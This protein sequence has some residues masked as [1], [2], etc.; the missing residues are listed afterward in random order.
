MFIAFC[1]ALGGLAL[2]LYG[3]HL[4]GRG[5]QGGDVRHVRAVLRLVTRGRFKAAASGSSGWKRLFADR[6]Q[7]VESRLSSLAARVLI[8]SI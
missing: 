1:E 4:A 8:P 3:M 6:A 5:L 7:P 2:L